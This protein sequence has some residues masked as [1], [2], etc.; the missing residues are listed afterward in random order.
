MRLMIAIVVVLMLVVPVR[1]T[2]SGEPKETET[3]KVQND[4]AK[5]RLYLSHKFDDF[6]INQKGERISYGFAYNKDTP[7]ELIKVPELKPF[8][9]K[10]RFFLTEFNYYDHYAHH[11]KIIVCITS[12]KS[13]DDFRYCFSPSH[14]EPNLKFLSLFYELSTK[15][16]DQRK[17]LATGLGALLAKVNSEYEIH[18][19]ISEFEIVTEI[20]FNNKPWRE[21]HVSFDRKGKSHRPYLTKPKD[22]G[23]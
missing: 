14:A 15:S 6:E 11:V 1:M 3:K 12:S 2:H 21:L 23:N 9:P 22:N 20:K 8:L 18:S 16:P 5:V 19:S 17:K 7:I 10:T 4:L 13:G